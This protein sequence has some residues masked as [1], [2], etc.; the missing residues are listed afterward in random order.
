MPR[1]RTSAPIILAIVVATGAAGTAARAGDNCLAAPNAAAPQGSHWYYRF[2]RAAHRKCWYLAAQGAKRRHAAA[3]TAP[4]AVQPDAPAA[5]VAPAADATAAALPAPAPSRP[6][7]GET[8]P[9]AAFASRWPQGADTGAIA[10]A[11]PPDDGRA[12]GVPATLASRG[13]AAAPAPTPGPDRIAA[14][15]VPTTAERAPA[16]PARARRAQPAPVSEPPAA[17]VADQRSGLPAALAAVALLLALVGAMLVRAGRRTLAPSGP[18][19]AP[20]PDARIAGFFTRIRRGLREVP[21]TAPLDANTSMRIRRGLR[22]PTD[23]DTRHFAPAAS[24]IAAATLQPVIAPMVPEAIDAAPDVERSLRQ[25][26]R[27]WE[28]MAA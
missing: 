7:G 1:M 24:D 23:A 4:A 25:L 15:A 26:L 16:E 21:A 18:D 19:E 10:G 28:R 9:D 17:A 3:A 13:A 27:A 8:V 20:G 22:S 5:P 6:I 2:D 12:T 14:R 11:P